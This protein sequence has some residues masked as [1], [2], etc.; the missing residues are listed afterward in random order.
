MDISVIIPTFKPGGYLWDS[1]L[2]LRCQTLSRKCYEIILV[3]NGDR[4]PYY[5]NIKS[6]LND[7]F[8][9]SYNIH[10]LYTEMANVSNARNL[11]LDTAKGDY[12]TFVD[13][14]DYVSENY[15][16]EL[17]KVA[18]VQTIALA[19]PVA[20][21][22]GKTVNYSIE[23]EYK[24]ISSKGI[25][26]F[27][28]ARRV[29]QGACIKLFHKSIIGNRR[30]NLSFKNSEDALFMFLVSDRFVNVCSTA[31]SAIYYRRIR[32]DGLY[33][34]KKTIGYSIQNAARLSFSYTKIYLS[35][36]WRYN[37]VFFLTR[38]LGTIKTLMKSI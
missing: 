33:R 1:L 23:N 12:I 4:E 25:V 29:F 28:Q 10:F 22:E 8:D 31:S 15:L 13:D 37:F 27:M 17:L 35:C 24:K 36:P 18:S 9:E 19:H 16:S 32:Q 20:V 6:F 3:L 21:S 26:P 34:R 7:E 30:F 11:G 2:S 14:D 38:I 5:S